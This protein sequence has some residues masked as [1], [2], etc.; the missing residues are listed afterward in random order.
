[1]SNSSGVDRQPSAKDYLLCYALWVVLFVLGLTAFVAWREAI[2][3]LIQLVNPQSFA[4]TAIQ[5]VLL[6]FVVIGV[7]AVLVGSE[8]YLRG[9]VERGRLMP[10]FMRIATPLAVAIVL[11][12]ILRFVA[13]ALIV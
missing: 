2:I 7:F 5:E 1:M 6:I 11:A 8:P 9:G 13:R 4:N 10:R 3:A 12:L